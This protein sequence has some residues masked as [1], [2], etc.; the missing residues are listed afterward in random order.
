[1]MLP[2]G[3][4]LLELTIV[5]A[6]IALLAAIGWPGYVGI[7]Q[8]TQRTDAHLALLRIQ[9]LQERHY[10]RYLRYASRLGAAPD[11]ETLPAEER[12]A[13]GHYL[14]TLRIAMEAQ[15]YTA[16]ATAAPTGRQSRDRDCRQLSVD[17]R[18]LRRSADAA[19]TWTSRDENR[20]WG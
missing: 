3:F 19:G 18:G 15:A 20:C 14:I 12:S 7:M 6:V 5:M 8:R 10:A 13:A 1:M 2:R 16:I 4:T 11:E 9:H 17:D